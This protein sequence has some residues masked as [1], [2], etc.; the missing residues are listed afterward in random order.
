[1]PTGDQGHGSGCGDADHA[2]TAV[3]VNLDRELVMWVEQVTT[4]SVVRIEHQGR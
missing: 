1:M 2:E 4:G 3:R